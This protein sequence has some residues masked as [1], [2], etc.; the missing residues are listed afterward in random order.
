M[1]SPSLTAPRPATTLSR[2]QD[3]KE[4]WEAKGRRNSG[5]LH[6]IDGYDLL[7]ADEYAAMIRALLAPF[8][9]RAGLHVI[10]LGCGAG[11]FLAALQQIE[12]NLT[13]AGLDYAES[14]I[15]VARARLS[16][17]F[18]VGDIRACPAV[19]S[20]SADLTC[21]FGVLLYLDSEDDVRRALGEIDRVTKPGGRIYIGEISDLARREEALHLRRFSHANHDRVSPKDLPHLYLPKTLFTEE[22]NRLGW[23]NT[24]IV[25]HSAVPGLSGNPLA[26]YRY[27]VY[28]EKR[29]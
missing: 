18:S 17:Q 23:E 19:A 26:G 16:G 6:L 27:S 2:N 13:L 10:E 14:L 29:S 11:A 12:S 3:W 24:R 5:E 1:S 9:L 20:A 8:P 25:D 15:G 28:A 22:A 4:I 21:S 7:S